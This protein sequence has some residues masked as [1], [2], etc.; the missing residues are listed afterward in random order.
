[1]AGQ[2]KFHIEDLPFAE[3][4]PSDV[5]DRRGEFSLF[6]AL[7]EAIE[8]ALEQGKWESVAILS[9]EYRALWADLE[10]DIG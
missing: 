8:G 7:E 10:K 3:S 4:T 5:A 6:N 9:S 1:M 2:K